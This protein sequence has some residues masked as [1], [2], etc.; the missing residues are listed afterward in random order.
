MTT[1]RAQV[2]ATSVEVWCPHCG[3]PQPSPTNGAFLWLLEEVEANQGA[4]MCDAC[5]ER[6]VLH[7]A[8]RVRVQGS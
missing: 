7:S 5:D 4:R 3:E 1:K 6:F 8:S 2:V